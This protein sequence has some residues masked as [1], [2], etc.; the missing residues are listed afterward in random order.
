MDYVFLS[1]L[2]ACKD[3]FLGKEVKVKGWIRNH[4]PQK[5]F[6]FI[7]FSDG[8]SF[9]HL[10]IVYTN[11][12]GDFDKITKLHNGSSI[13]VTGLFTTSE[14][15]GQDY[16]LKATS[17]VLLGDCSEDYPLQPKKHSMEFLRS[18]AYLRPRSN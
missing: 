17:V 12:L 16:E 3:E 13:E 9:K 6:G 5:E 11:E 8:T 1:D 4:R 15:K 10:Q 18:I 7:D 14:G 2:Y